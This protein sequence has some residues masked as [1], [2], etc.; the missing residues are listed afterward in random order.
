ML[1]AADDVGLPADP[2]LRSTF[3]AY[4]EWGTRL[5]V[6]NSQPDA[7]VMEHAPVPTGAGAK[8]RP[9]NPN[10]GTIP[11]PPN[12]DGAARHSRSRRPTAVSPPEKREHR[13]SRPTRES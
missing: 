8:P 11:A 9:S 10:P 1:E 6:A 12:R 13:P 7:T 4:V 3:V 5:A 2:G